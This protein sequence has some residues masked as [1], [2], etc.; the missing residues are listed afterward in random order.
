[1]GTLF[2]DRFNLRNNLHRL[3]VVSG[4]GNVD[5]RI[6]QRDLL[7]LS[8]TRFS[9]IRFNWATNASGGVAYNPGTGTR[10]FDAIDFRDGKRILF[11]GIDHIRFKDRVIDRTIVPNDPLFSQ[12]WNLHMMGVHTAWRLTTGSDRVAIGIA[13]SGLGANAFGGIHPD[14]RATTTNL[15]GDYQDDFFDNFFFASSGSQP[16]SHGTAVQGIIAAAS[17]NRYGMS[18]INWN[19]RVINLDVLGGQYSD[20]SLENAAQTIINDASYLGQRLVINQK[21]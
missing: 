20:F 3:T 12:Q 21:C 13:D 1:V 4:N 9:S 16:N 5:F 18:G 10:I 6:G 8:N 7:D 2:A 11:E 14:L 15:Y 17:N 19:S